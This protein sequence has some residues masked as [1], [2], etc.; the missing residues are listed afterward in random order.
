VFRT[1]RIVIAL[2]G[3]LI[4]LV[5]VCVSEVRG[6]VSGA[7]AGVTSVGGAIAF[8]C[9]AISVVGRRRCRRSILRPTVIPVNH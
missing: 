4:P 9:V 5:R 6:Q 3:D 8:A 1:L 2:V 7:G